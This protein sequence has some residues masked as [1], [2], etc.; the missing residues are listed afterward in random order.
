V[1]YN[2][3]TT[4]QV[5]YLTGKFNKS[6]F[7]KSTQPTPDQAVTLQTLHRRFAHAGNTA[8][9]HIPAAT[10][11]IKL[12]GDNIDPL[13]TEPTPECE[14][15]H[16]AK[17]KK[18]VKRVPI[19][20]PTAP[21]EVVA[22]DLIE[23]QLVKQDAG[24]GK[25]ILHFYYRYSGMN[26]IYVLPH[27][28]EQLILSTI[29]DFSAYTLRRWKL[30]IRII[31]ADGETSMGSTTE[32]WLAKQGITLNRSP[33][34]TQDQNGAAERSGGVIITM[35]RAIHI[36]SELPGYMWP[37]VATATGYLLNRTPRQKYQWKTLW[38]VFQKY[39]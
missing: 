14:V 16:V 37:E 20:P 19:P 13:G 26:H 23:F 27:K 25:Y 36:D 17:G 31:Q 15:C 22:M 5:A 1:E 6:R 9:K 4:Q 33:P 39:A 38:E 18:I 11:G 30:P 7:T 35:A 34:Y 3:T 29:Q 24:Y 28:G 12:I 32:H 10:Q 8:T 2:K 21:Y